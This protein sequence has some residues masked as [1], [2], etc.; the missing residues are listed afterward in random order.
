MSPLSVSVSIGIINCIFIKLS[1]NVKRTEWFR[2]SCTWLYMCLCF[3]WCFYIHPDGL[4]SADTCLHRSLGHFCK[5]RRVCHFISTYFPHSLLSPLVLSSKARV[6][7]HAEDA[8]MAYPA[9]ASWS[10]HFFF[11][12]LFIFVGSQDRSVG[13]YF[14]QRLLTSTL[15]IGF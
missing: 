4:C 13:A 3:A 7:K 9:S 15:S 10:G 12:I 14:N 5:Y 1:M 11:E 6:E 8:I 2:V